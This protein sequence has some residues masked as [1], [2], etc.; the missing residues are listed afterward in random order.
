MKAVDMFLME[1]LSPVISFPQVSRSPIPQ[2]RPWAQAI[3]RPAAE[4][5]LT[6]LPVV[7]GQVPA[8]L[9]GS[10]YRNGPGRLRRNG[11]AVGHWF[12]GDGAILAVHFADGQARA[13]YR[14]V[15]TAGYQ[16]ETAAERYLFGGYG[17][18]TPK[19]WLQ[20][21]GQDLKN[22]A[23]TSVLPLDDRL[24]ALWEGGLPHALDLETLATRGLD[25]LT[26][27]GGSLRSPHGSL[28]Y[29]AHPKQ[30][31]RTGHLFNFG[32]A[33]G[34]KMQL[35]LHRSDRTGAIERQ[36]RLPLDQFALIHDSVWTGRYWVFCLPP[37]GLKLW[38]ALLQWQS[39]SQAL[40][41]RGDRPTTL[42]VIDGD[43]LELV[44]QIE[45]DPW[46]QWHL[47]NGWQESDQVL[48]FHVVR[49][50][51]F[52]TNQFLGE[53][54]SGQTRT[55]AP[56]QLWEVRLD[57]R[58]GQILSNVPVSE[59]MCEFPTWSS[60]SHTH[61][62]RYTYLS[63]HREAIAHNPAQYCQELFG[64]IARCDHATGEWS[65]AE[66]GA[67]G[68]LSEPLLALDPTVDHE[69]GRGSDQG[70]ILSTLYDGKRDASE[71]WIWQSDRL[72]EDPIARLALPDV[73]P[74]GFHGVWRSA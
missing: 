60:Q 1:A 72:T 29:S 20:R 47:G 32:V 17:T 58:T 35:C 55:A 46:Y 7:A 8:N 62:H 61:R 48:G 64:A 51:D 25:A 31:P 56:S 12:D 54:A 34:A 14:Y 68:Y 36:A 2:H 73:V 3:A 18:L 66:A 38:P 11:Q 63:V 23:N 43:T 28:T 67:E 13:T 52:A 5:P 24:L 26:G 21:F 33:I 71:L 74:P 4:F 9:R 16:A 40:H 27:S 6:E 41:W 42:W 49:Y 70:W 39:F 59:R 57:L 19:P 22:A 53:V 45:A 37:V 44:S 30:D 50:E 15:Q 65:I 69:A 10:L